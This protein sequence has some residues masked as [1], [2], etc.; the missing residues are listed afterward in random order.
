MTSTIK[1]K[2]AAKYLGISYWKIL[3]MAKA[4]EVPHV[5]A[6]RRVLF[7]RET[8]DRWMAAQEAESVQQDNESAGVRQFV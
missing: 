1:A 3:E 4:G 8:L 5:R 7:R 6:G 2:D